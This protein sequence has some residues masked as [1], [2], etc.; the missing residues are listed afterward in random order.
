MN[1]IIILQILLIFKDYPIKLLLNFLWI[2]FEFL[3]FIHTHILTHI[4]SGLFP[5]LCKYICIYVYF[6]NLKLGRFL[7]ISRNFFFLFNFHLRY[8]LHSESNLTFFHRGRKFH[9]FIRFFRFFLIIICLRFN[10]GN[11][12]L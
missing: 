12:S 11:K 5:V 2:I 3:F 9:L 1:R 4:F 10:Y 8:C 7:I 6:F